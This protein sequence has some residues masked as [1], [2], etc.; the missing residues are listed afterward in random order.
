MVGFVLYLL[1]VGTLVGLLARAFL[2]GPNPMSARATIV[3]G[4]LGS[5]VSGFFGWAFFGRDF[6]DGVM[7]SPGI[8][9]SIAG[10]AVLLFIYRTLS[11]PADPPSRVHM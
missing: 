7:R 11:R 5:F 10:A 8:I 3:L 1:I 2:P 6:T 4:V 9:G